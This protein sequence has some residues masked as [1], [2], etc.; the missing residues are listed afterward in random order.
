MTIYKNISCKELAFS[1]NKNK[2][3]DSGNLFSMTHIF[4]NEKTKINTVQVCRSLF[5]LPHVVYREQVTRFTQSGPTNRE[6][7]IHTPPFLLSATPADRS[8]LH[9]WIFQLS[10]MTKFQTAHFNESSLKSLWVSDV[11]KC[12]YKTNVYLFQAL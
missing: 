4:N 7:H 9:E 2:M 5:I 8:M 3:R 10:E 1:L 6:L 11:S 12:I